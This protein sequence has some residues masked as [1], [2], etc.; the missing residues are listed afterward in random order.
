M[1][2][3]IDVDVENDDDD[4]DAN[5]YIGKRQFNDEEEWDD[6]FQ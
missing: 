3:Y 6:G 5:N 1:R 2:K 4:Y